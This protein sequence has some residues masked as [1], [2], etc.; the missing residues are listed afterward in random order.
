MRKK[1]ISIS[2][3]ASMIIGNVQGVEHIFADE[4]KSNILSSKRLDEK[5]VKEENNLKNLSL[6]SS[7]ET[8]TYGNYKY[9]ID[10]S[11]VTITGYTGGD[12]NLVIPSEI[13]G[14]KVTKIGDS[15]FKDCTSLT[16][17]KISDNI[18]GIGKSAFYNCSEL[19]SVD[20][21]NSVTWIGENAFYDCP[22]KNLELPPNLETLGGSAFNS[23]YITS[24]KIPKTLT[25]AYSGYE[26]DPFPA[27]RQCENLQRVEFEKGLK[28]IPKYILLGCVNLKEVIMPDSIEKIGYYAFCD[29]KSLQTIEIPDNVK[30]ISRTAFGGCEELREVK[31]GKNTTYIGYYAFGDCSKLE[32]ITISDKIETLY[33][34]AFWNTNIKEI[35]V[36]ESVESISDEY[37][38]LGLNSLEKITVDENN[39]NYIVEDD[40]LYNKEKTKLIK[41]PCNKEKQV[42]EVPDSVVS[43]ANN[44][45]YG[46]NKL[47]E[48]KLGKSV[49]EI[50]DYAFSDCSNLQ[51][52]IIASK[53]SDVGNYAFGYRI[54]EIVFL[55]TVESISD[56]YFKNLSH[57]E[58]ITVSENN[59]NYI[60]EDD[61]LYNK[62]KTELIKCPCNKEAQI[63]EIPDS[64]VTIGN[65]AFF[66]C[67]KLVE[68]KLGKSVSNIGNKAFAS[69]DKLEKL[70]IPNKSSNVAE[71]SFLNTEIKE[72]VLSDTVE[73]I[74]DKYFANL[75]TLE[76]ITVD[77]NNQ[78][79]ISID[80]SLYNKDK[81]KL[82]KYLNESQNENAVIEKTVTSLGQYAFTYCK[83][84]KNV[85]LPDGIKEIGDDTFSN[86]TSLET[87]N[88]PDSITKIGNKAFYECPLK[89]LVLPKNLQHIGYNVATSQSITSIKIPKT[90]V[91]ASLGEDFEIGDWGETLK[92]LVGPFTNCNNLLTMEFED[93]IER[94]PDNVIIKYWGD[95]KN[96]IIPASVTSIGKNLTNIYGPT[97][98]GITIYGYAGS[99]AETYANENNIK[100]VDLEEVENFKALRTSSTSI[101]LS[102]DKVSD[103]NGYEIFRATSENGKYIKVKTITNNDTITNTSTGLQDGTSYYY[104]IKAYK[105]TDGKKEYI[106]QASLK[107]VTNP[108]KPI[109]LKAVNSTKN[110][111]QISWDKVDRATGY[112]V[113]RSTSENSNYVR[114]KTITDNNT[115][116]IISPNLK[117]DTTYYYRVKAYIEVD[118]KKIYS[119]SATLK[120]ATLKPINIT[121]LKMVANS[122]NSIRISWKQV[123]DVDGYE[124]FRSTDKNGK[125]TK[126]K[127]ITNNTTV[128]IA[129]PNLQK[130]TT[131]YY[132]VRAYK[133]VGEN[134]QYG[135]FS[136]IET[137]TKPDAVNNLNAIFITDKSVKI[138]WNK[139]NGADKY[140]VFRSTSENGSYVKVGTT[141]SLNYT[142]TKVISG[143]TYYY[144]VKAYRLI[145]TTKIYGGYSDILNIT[146]K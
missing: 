19:T 55:D 113:F 118:G 66:S 61:I 98:Y 95:L 137:S 52:L 90:L 85:N 136:L 64:V 130:G 96:I 131:Y 125:Y 13:S 106:K 44:A 134:K 48:V 40:I 110:S 45:F 97:I 82:I 103:A 108:V 35:V 94:I 58:K 79:Y 76:K 74:A 89:Q 11:E 50:G 60:V 1:I 92:Y 144:K 72:I 80:G 83:Y 129:S 51:K 15:A 31:L 109:N 117:E 8:L 73:S 20:F 42:F 126:I 105:E 65:N 53:S 14:L 146:I 24:L 23:D 141:N 99:Y 57:L 100:F 140:E 122:T 91:S 102:W 123:D 87:I 27:F 112:E 46:C 16:S 127:T 115:T 12:K 145:G 2:L 34:D 6:S 70:V 114:V 67:D 101:V 3:A 78:N 25:V 4:V 143:Q 17:V 77:E 39:K 135:E 37:L 22:L 9:V 132:K 93:G 69:C 75:E 116:Q 36:P 43:I 68:V 88:L 7:S 142:S 59:K 32:K 29:C 104:K 121:E 30:S 5:K 139:V 84:I 28:E 10:D 21:S 38:N 62:E 81:T 107:A 86:C 111:I 54:K 124:V 41:C 128:S 71:D 18:K 120:A 26:D 49:N 119:N 133:T 47:V 56:R 138:G 63:L 33:S